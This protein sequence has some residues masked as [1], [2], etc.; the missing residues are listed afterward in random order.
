MTNFPKVAELQQKCPNFEQIFNYLAREI[1]REDEHA[2]ILAP[3]QEYTLC[4]NGFRNESIMI[5]V[6]DG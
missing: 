3:S 5:K 1:L 2:T 4:A 6:G